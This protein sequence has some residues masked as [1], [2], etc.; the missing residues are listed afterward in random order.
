[1][2]VINFVLPGAGANV[3]EAERPTAGGAARAPRLDGENVGAEQSD[4]VS[5]LQPPHQVTVIIM[6]AMVND[7]WSSWW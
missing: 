7:H 6:V 5:G 3:A 1:M 4:E 2:V